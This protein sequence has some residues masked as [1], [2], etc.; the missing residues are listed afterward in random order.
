MATIEEIITDILQREGGL[1]NNP[2]DKGGRTDKGVSERYHPE[3]WADGKVTEAEAR[4]I[5]LKKYV[6]TPGFD[7]IKGSHLQT[8]LVDFGVHSGPQLAIMKL[9]GIIGTKQDGILGPKS[10]TTLGEMDPKYVNNRLM[11]ERIRMIGRIVGRDRSQA[12]F[13]NGWLERACQFLR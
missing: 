3:A 7:K 1:V 10:L 13:L 2:A 5:Y 6:L 11:V 9:Q 12:Q 4:T 8:Q